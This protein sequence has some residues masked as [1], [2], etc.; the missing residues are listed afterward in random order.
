MAEVK[1]PPVQTEYFPLSGGLNVVD[2]QIAIKPGVAISA[3]NYEVSPD[4]GYSRVGG[5]ER[6]DGRPKPSD[7][8]FTVLYATTTFSATV[9]VGQTITGQTSSASAKIIVVST[10]FKYVV[11]TKKVGEFQLG[12]NLQ[13]SSVTVAVNGAPN[14]TLTQFDDNKFAA[15]AEDEYRADIQA[16]PGSGPVRGVWSLKN[17]VYCFRNNVGATQCIMYK[18]TSTG[19][20]QVNLGF[21]LKF[22]SGDT[23]TAIVDGQTVVGGTSGATGVVKRVVVQS[24]SNWAAATPCSGRLIF[25]SITGT[26]QNGEDIK[27]SGVRRATCVGTQSAITLQPGGRFEFDNYNFTGSADTLRMYGCDGVNRGF[28]FDGNVFVPIET[29]MSQDSP[30]FV[31]CHKGHLFFAF[32]G[33]LQHSSIGEPYRWSVIVGGASELGLGDD[34]T[35]LHVVSGSEG[36]AALMVFCR[37]RIF[38]LY[39]NSSADWNLVVLS[40]K[41]GAIPYTTQLVVSPVFLDDLGITTSEQSMVFGNFKHGIISDKVFPILSRI[42]ADAVASTVVRTKNQYKLFFK[43]GYGLTV[44]FMGRQTAGV[45]P[46]S[47]PAIV[48]CTCNA[49]VNGKETILFG[50]TNG[51]VYELNKGRGFDGAEIKALVKTTFNHSRSPRTRKRYRKAVFDL[52]PTS[53]CKFSIQP[54]LSYS[55]GDSL[56]QNAVVKSASGP[57]GRWDDATWDVSNWDGNDFTS[58]DVSLDGVGTNISFSITST[59]SNELPHT[60]QGVTIHYTPRRLER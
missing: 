46:F 31:R 35:G 19:W 8:I 56:S 23:G 49:E 39:G 48:S 54:E 9:A 30:K 55:V 58:V 22:N 7:A 41:T 38:V 34:C 52:K 51:F 42:V 1:M 47:T 26:F 11:V 3:S 18:A 4:G 27:V 17:E 20:Q 13:V 50:A 14:T 12:E 16:P 15:A 59:A 10:D 6:F 25:A 24:G 33:S 45:M 44:T 57:G 5:Y 43:D 53:A 60:I 32:K 29:G 37:N 28:E 40:D 36:H 2:P 21:E